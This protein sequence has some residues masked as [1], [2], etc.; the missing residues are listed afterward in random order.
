MIYI[1]YGYNHKLNKNIVVISYFRFL[2]FML[3]KAL[4]EDNNTNTELAAE[5]EALYDDCCILYIYCFL[6]S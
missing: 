5:K 6:Y 4:K 2:V 1:M 3:H